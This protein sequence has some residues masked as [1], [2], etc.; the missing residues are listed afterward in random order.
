MF[1]TEGLG[2]D[3]EENAI[4]DYDSV[5]IKDF[6]DYIKFEDAHYNVKLP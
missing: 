2:I 3:S 6:E 4:T 5:K 1:Q